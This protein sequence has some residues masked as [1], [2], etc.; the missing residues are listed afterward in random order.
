MSKKIPSVQLCKQQ[1]TFHRNKYEIE[2]HS[3]NRLKK[4]EGYQEPLYNYP[5]LISI[6]SKLPLYQIIINYL[7][8]LNCTI[9]CQGLMYT[10]YNTIISCSLPE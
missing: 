7:T 6:Y 3:K 8:A 4:K 10:E 5:E 1:K 2:Q 9:V